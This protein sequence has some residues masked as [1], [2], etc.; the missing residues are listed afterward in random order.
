M[1]R[2]SD[3]DINRV[4]DAT[5][6]VQVVA[7]YV[8]LRQR[9]REFWGNCPFHNDK[10][11][12]FHVRPHLQTWHCFSCGEGGDVFKFIMKK[13]QFEFPEAVRY[14]AGKAGITITEEEGG[15]PSGYRGRLLAAC[16]EAAAFYHTQLMRGKSEGCDNARKYLGARGFG[17]KVP[18]RWNLGYAPGGNALVRH[19]RAKGFTDKEMID[20]NVAL[21]SE[22]GGVR[23][24]FYN[25]VMFP[26]RDLQ[27]RTIAFG[28]RVIG[29]GEPKYINTSNCP[30]FSKRNNLFGIDYAKSSITSKATSIVVEGYTDVIAMHENGFENTVA[31]LGTALTPQHVKLLTRFASRVVYLFDGDAAGQKAADRAAELITASVAPESGGR[32]VSLQVAVIPN[33]QDPVEFIDAEGREAM[34]GL[35]DNAQPLLRFVID[36]R[37]AACDLSTPEQRAL[38]LPRV[39]EP[40]VPIRDSILADEYIVYLA[41]VFKVDFARMRKELDAARAPRAYQRDDEYGDSY[42]PVPGPMP[43]PDPLFRIPQSGAGRW[44]AQLLNIYLANPQV[45]T[46]IAAAMKGER[47]SNE[48]FERVFGVLL[49]QP[50]DAS[51]AG[52][53]VACMDA[54]PQSEPIWNMDVPTDEDPRRLEATVVLMLRERRKASIEDRIADLEQ[55]VKYDRSLTPEQEGSL[56]E[57]IASLQKE[58]GALRLEQG[59][60]KSMLD[61]LNQS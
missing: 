21:S 55:R 20:A 9:G 30:L 4:R 7:E 12:S 60:S 11:P 44:E 48:L 2:I 54:E 19:L 47:W 59:D 14:L 34:Q 32:Q 52:L 1:G 3:E 56:F 16:E 38:A 45:R 25:R 15:L 23:D 26:I 17:G 61:N 24:R 39:L 46:R 22:R 53:V 49:S 41:D 29:S 18:K 57:E 35:L 43:A 40:L 10:T 31:T 42:A 13:E 36:R 33:S 37:L 27:G 51:P 5:D 28:G 50:S 58:L 6:I 8:E